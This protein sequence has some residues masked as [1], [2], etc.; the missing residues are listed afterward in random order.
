[1]K[2]NIRKIT[3]G[4]EESFFE[5]C[6][7]GMVFNYSQAFFPKDVRKI[8]E[9]HGVVVEYCEPGTPEYKE[10]GCHTMKVISI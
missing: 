9:K 10:H 8:A 1:M 2:T 6:H 5:I 3:E 4:N 7:E